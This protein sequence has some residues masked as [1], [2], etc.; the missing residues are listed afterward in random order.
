MLL[1]GLQTPSTDDVSNK[2]ILS[3][4]DLHHLKPQTDRETKDLMADL[5]LMILIFTA[6][7]NL[8]W[9]AVYSSHWNKHLTEFQMQNPGDTLLE[10]S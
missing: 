10:L 4:P 9:T 2:K 8:E 5:S 3:L 6:T 7:L 1:C